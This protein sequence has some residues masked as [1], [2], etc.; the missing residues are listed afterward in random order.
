MIS[1]CRAK[2]TL[3]DRS[4]VKKVFYFYL[5]MNYRLNGCFM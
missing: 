5:D 4:Q 3:C 1:Y 2:G